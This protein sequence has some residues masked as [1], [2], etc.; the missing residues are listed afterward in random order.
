MSLCCLRISVTTGSTEE[1]IGQHGITGDTVNLAARLRDMAESGDVLV[2]GRAFSAAAGFFT[3]QPLT[4]MQVKG[5]QQPVQIY[6]VIDMLNR[7]FD[8]HEADED[9]VIAA[10]LES[11]IQS[12]VGDATEVLPFFSGLY[13]ITPSERQMLHADR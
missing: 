12:L 8:I 3:F 7:L 11:G 6:R 10:K 4:R 1:Q 2:D 9:A 5:R 13:A